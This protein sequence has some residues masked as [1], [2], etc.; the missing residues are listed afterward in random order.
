[1]KRVDFNLLV[2]LRVVVILLIKR[3]LRSSLASLFYRLSSSRSHG[4]FLRPAGARFQ[5]KKTEGFD[6]YVGAA[7]PLYIIGP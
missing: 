6:F 4:M 1:L 5:L 7:S 2:I 3:R